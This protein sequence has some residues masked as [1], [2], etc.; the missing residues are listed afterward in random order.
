MKSR[1]DLIGN[2]LVVKVLLVAVLWTNR[3]GLDSSP[4][5]QERHSGY[6]CS[7]YASY[8]LICSHKS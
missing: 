7:D 2:G 4:Y 3:L 1:L 5:C 8:I 6:L